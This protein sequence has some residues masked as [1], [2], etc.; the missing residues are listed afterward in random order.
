MCTVVKQIHFWSFFN[1][2]TNYAYVWITKIPLLVNKMIKYYV[3]NY[4]FLLNTS[5]Q[6]QH[7]VVAIGLSL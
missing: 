5:H 1:C 7:G 4:I 6:H 2:A 3:V